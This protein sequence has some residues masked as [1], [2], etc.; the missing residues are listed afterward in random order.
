MTKGYMVTTKE[1]IDIAE[2]YIANNN[3]DALVIS[4]TT[5]F[6]AYEY[7]KRGILNNVNCFI[8]TQKLSEEI[9]MKEEVRNH[10]KN[11]GFNVI[12]IPH[13]YLTHKLGTKGVEILRSFSQGTK[14][15]IELIEFLLEKD[16]LIDKKNVLAI[17]GTGSGADTILA[18]KLKSSKYKVCIIKLPIS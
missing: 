7:E 16:Y 3:I 12:D 14:V 2:K 17:A 11:S 18:F 10:F 4:S 8:C 6:T 13:Q 9:Y 15:C 5:G 1:M